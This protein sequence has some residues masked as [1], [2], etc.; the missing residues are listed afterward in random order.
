MRMSD[1]Y[2]SRAA[3]GPK[4]EEPLTSVGLSEMSEDE[5]NLAEKLQ[6]VYETIL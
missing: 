5:A 3:T 6:V 1:D 4:R 2:L